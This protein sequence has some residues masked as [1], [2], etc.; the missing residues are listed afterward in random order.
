VRGR[1]LASG[2]AVIAAAA[3]VAVAFWLVLF[4][5]GNRFP[6]VDLAV[7]RAG[8]RAVLDGRALYTMH[9]PGTGL[10]FT[11]PPF[12]ALAFVPLA[13]IGV[14][15]GQ[16]LFSVVSLL[17]LG[18]V[19]WVVVGRALPPTTDAALR[20]SGAAVVGA[21]ALS[22]EPVLST[23]SFGQVNLVLLAL[24]VEDLLGSVPARFRGVLV[25]VAAGLKITPALFVVY[26]VVVG[27]YRDAARAVAG[28]AVTLALGFA[29]LP[30]AS[31]RYWTGIAY[32]ARRVGGVAYAGN[33]SIDAVLIRL[34]S[35]DGARLAWLAAAAVVTVVALL[36]ARAASRTG[37]EVVAVTVVG[38]ASLL[39]SPVAW[40]HHWVWSALVVAVLGAD[41]L[42]RREAP[43]RLTLGLLV[44]VVAVFVSRIIWWVPA[45]HDV[46][47][48]WRGWQLVA[49]NAYVI[50]GL[51]FLAWATA[52]VRTQF[53][54]RRAVR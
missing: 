4:V 44:L 9:A 11:Y 47:Y 24:I 31:W 27:R 34:S 14:G 1:R 40:N 5:R 3:V 25:G 30:D 52:L 54:P 8:G 26:L 7:Y 38:V 36:T 53:W 51:L 39:A 46:E 49:G 20:F 50:V 45:T 15:L 6:M 43:R 12:A 32:D 21:L 42:V 19:V 17:A 13:A 29:L 28:F 16:L 2:S 41:L 22:F 18:R 23:L 48:R 35:I 37:R 33:Q 10:P